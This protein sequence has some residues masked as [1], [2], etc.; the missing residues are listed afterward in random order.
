M[1]LVN[2]KK[3]LKVVTQPRGQKEEEPE[4]QCPYEKSVEYVPTEYE[5]K[6][7]ATGIFK[8]DTVTI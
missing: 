6:I 5:D 4:H 7:P 8:I 1:N 3:K 2:G